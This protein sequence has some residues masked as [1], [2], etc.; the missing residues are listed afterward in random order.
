MHACEIHAHK[1]YAYEMHAHETHAHETHAHEM[2]AYEVH[3]HEVY[4]HEMHACKMH[5][6][7]MHAREVHAH[8]T[9]A[10]EIHAR[11]MHAREV[12]AHETLTNG[13][14]VV[15]LSRSELQKT[16]FYAS[17]G[18]V[19]IARR[20]STDVARRRRMSRNLGGCLGEPW[21]IYYLEWSSLGRVGLAEQH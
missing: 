21:C 12:H 7:E 2:H 9:H 11:E 17:C 14:A 16:S 8:E 19:P 18:V 3:A 15:D 10:Y 1:T 20:R 13:G 5:A 4:P 6:H